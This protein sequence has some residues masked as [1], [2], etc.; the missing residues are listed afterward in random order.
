MED[1]IIKNEMQEISPEGIPGSDTAGFR[2]EANLS[3]SSQSKES[4]RPISELKTEV[5]SGKKL[6]YYETGNKDAEFTVLNIS[7]LGAGSGEGNLRLDQALNGEIENSKGMQTLRTDLPKGA[8]KIE[9]IIKGLKGKYHTITP[10][11]PGFGFSEAIDDPTLDGLA[12]HLAEFAKQKGLRKM[13][14]FGSSM[15]GTLAIRIAARHPELAGALALQGVMTGPSDMRK[16][17]YIPAQFF[18]ATPMRQMIE[19]IPGGS[20]VMKKILKFG[21]RGQIDFQ[22]ADEQGK[23]QMLRDT[24]KAEAHTYLLALRGIGKDLKEEIGKIEVPVLLLDG[25]NSVVVSIDKTKRIASRFHPEIS[26][27]DPRENLRKKIAG[28]K[29]LFYKLGGVTGKH[30]HSVLNTAPEIMAVMLNHATKYFKLNK[31][32]GIAR[33]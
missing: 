4:E 12:D 17:D 6:N 5:V 18:T 15:G 11:I 1:A 13:I 14:L 8:E 2:A 7:G 16:Q 30:A 26:D 31:N 29:V 21:T 33:S 19:H 27:E 9:E 22:L 32:A 20:S 28:K 24:D 25:K 23:E 3:G 10:Q